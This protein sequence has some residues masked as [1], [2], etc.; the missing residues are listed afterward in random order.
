MNETG[1]PSRDWSIILLTVWLTSRLFWSCD[2]SGFAFDYLWG[3]IGVV[4]AGCWFYFKKG[5]F[6][7]LVSADLLVAAFFCLYVL[8]GALGVIH[9]DQ[10]AALNCLWST[11]FYALIYLLVRQIVVTSDRKRILL[12]SLMCGAVVLSTWAVYQRYVEY[13]ADKAKYQENPAVYLQQIGIDPSEDSP[14]RRSFEDRFFAFEPSASFSLTNSLAAFLTPCFVLLAAAWAQNWNRRAGWGLV[15]AMGFV[16]FA[17]ALTHAR[18]AML[19][20][21]FALFC[22]AVYGFARVP[23]YAK[24]KWL[25][26]LIFVILTTFAGTVVLIL[27]PSL[28]DSAMLTLEYRFE[29][30]DSALQMIW[31]HP[32]LGVGAGNF[33][34]YYTQFMPSTAGEAVADPHNFLL[35]IAAVS[36]IPAS[37]I[38]WFLLG[39]LGYKLVLN[40]DKSSNDVPPLSLKLSLAISLASLVIGYGLGFLAMGQTPG[41]F[42]VLLCASVAAP[43]L[44]VPGISQT[45][46]SPVTITLA[47]IGLLTALMLSGGIAYTTIAAVFWTLTALIVNQTFV[48]EQEPQ[49]APASSP[50]ASRLT[51][52]GLCVLFALCYFTG[53]YPTTESARAR[54]A[55]LQDTTPESQLADLEQSVKADSIAFQPR[56]DLAQWNW[57]QWT[58]TKNNENFDQCVE[59]FHQALE[60][61][62]QS[63]VLWRE[64]GIRLYKYGRESG[65]WSHENDAYAA[66]NS[67]CL[68][69]QADY[70]AR[71]YLALLDLTSPVLTPSQ[72]EM[73]RK[74]LSA[75]DDSNNRVEESR[76]LIT[77]TLLK[78]RRQDAQ[79]W[80]REL[81]EFSDNNIHQNRKIPASL[82][83]KLIQTIGDKPEK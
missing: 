11:A 50:F 8:S 42:I 54:M 13:P 71:A 15:A 64:Y 80:A 69:H 36:G 3:L 30:W 25:I 81:I 14:A 82:R 19:G 20:I 47:L 59:M 40:P 31:H 53:F 29:Y 38:F 77:A 18:A 56:F 70:V 39:Y 46:F 73:C 17:V 7:R 57:T 66:L 79:R 23:G 49:A 33:Q 43:L 63:S 48:S 52:A 76:A 21:A 37:L 83:E 68:L 41:P 55:S 60:R 24:A 61:N 35:E 67:A 51:V 5:T 75:L 32:W 72:E 45:K 65:D 27:K 12:S 58:R 4:G 6:G 16:A 9:G 74:A 2:P 62:P 34:N 22:G 10:R 1:K 26:M 28:L 44:I 78:K